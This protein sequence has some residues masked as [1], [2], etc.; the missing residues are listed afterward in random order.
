MD[1]YPFLVVGGFSQNQLKL[2]F[3]VGEWWLV[4]REEGLCGNSPFL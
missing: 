1:L 2:R 3:M 4:R